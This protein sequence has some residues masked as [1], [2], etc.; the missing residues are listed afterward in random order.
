MT[1]LIYIPTD[2]QT[3]DDIGVTDEPADV[4]IYRTWNHRRYGAKLG[5]ELAAPPWEGG[6]EAA[7]EA[8]KED[9]KELPWDA[10]HRAFNKAGKEWEADFKHLN[11]VVEHMTE[12]GW[13]VTVGLDVAKEFEAEGFKFLPSHRDNEAEA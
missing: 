7:F 10:T 12:H 8:C 4:H 2:A 6:D 13:D 3:A 11:W 9:F 1:Q 5:I